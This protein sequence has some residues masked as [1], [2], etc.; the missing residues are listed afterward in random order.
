MT[1]LESKQVG[2]RLFRHSGF[3]IPSDFVIRALSF[4]RYE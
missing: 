2:R 1:K 3:V 4:L